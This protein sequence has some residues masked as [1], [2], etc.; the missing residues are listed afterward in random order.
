MVAGWA[1]FVGPGCF[2]CPWAAA[3]PRAVRAAS[4]RLGASSRSPARPRHR[5]RAPQPGAY[6]DPVARPQPSRPAL[7][8]L[9]P[10]PTRNFACN[11]PETISNLQ[12][13]SLELQRFQTLLK[14]LPIELH[15]TFLEGR[16]RHYQRAPQP[17]HNTRR[18]PHLKPVTP[19]RV[20]HCHEMKPPTPLRA[21]CRTRLKPL[22]PLLA[23]KSQF[24]AVFHPQ[25]CHGFHAPLAEYP[26]RRRRFHPR[27]TLRPQPKPRVACAHATRPVAHWPHD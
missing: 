21:P 3:R 10:K 14:L 1:F 20:A 4:L 17:P 18:P 2:V 25:R 12:F 6:W 26:Q 24:Q 11:S 13:R 23:Q 22:T 15:A 8:P 7:T 5:P 16:P 19:M 27:R 9:I